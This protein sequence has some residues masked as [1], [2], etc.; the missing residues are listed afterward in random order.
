MTSN[1]T[2]TRRRDPH[3]KDGWLIY[4]G[5]VHVGSIARAAGPPNAAVQWTWS[6]GFYPGSAPG[7]Q[8]HGTADSFDAA[9]AEFERAW[10]AFSAK[11]TEGRR[12]G[13]RAGRGSRRR[14]VRD[15]H[16]RNSA[17]HG[18]QGDPREAKPVLE[19]V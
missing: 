7:E 18:S 12:S 3:R 9:R 14:A 4:L 6:C 5:D 17:G 11:R 2:L 13:G 10:M 1:Q 19:C 15:A 8:T 16:P